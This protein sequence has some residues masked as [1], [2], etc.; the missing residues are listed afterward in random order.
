MCWK[1]LHAVSCSNQGDRSGLAGTKV[2]V[3]AAKYPKLKLSLEHASEGDALTCLALRTTVISLL[4]GIWSNI[5]VWGASQMI[6][7]I[8]N[9]PAKQEIQVWSLGQE[10]PLEKE[11]PTHSSI[12]GWEIPWT[13]E[14]GR[15]QSMGTQRVRHDWPHTQISLWRRACSVPGSWKNTVF[16][17]LLTLGQLCTRPIVTVTLSFSLLGW[18]RLSSTTF[19][20]VCDEYENRIM[21]KCDTFVLTKLLS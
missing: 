5:P 1:T 18:T 17:N 21:E 10:D 11:T 13:K 12:L 20:F 3:K 16:H 2:R 4:E 8:K 9:L 15:L 14:P 19:P 6:L 7:V